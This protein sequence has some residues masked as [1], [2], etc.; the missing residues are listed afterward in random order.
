METL[1]LLSIARTYRRY[2]L[3]GALLG[4]VAIAAAWRVAPKRYQATAYVYLD[5]ASNALTQPG[6]LQGATFSQVEIA[7]SEKVALQTLATLDPSARA[8]MGL[9]GDDAVTLVRRRIEVK[10]G[11]DSSVMQLVAGQPVPEDA[12]ALANAAAAAYLRVSAAL[13]AAPARQRASYYDTKVSDLQAAALAAQTEVAAFQRRTG[14]VNAAT[15][16][17][18][19]EQAMLGELIRRTTELRAQYLGNAAGRNGVLANPEGSSE[20]LASPVVQ[21]LRVDVARARTR[22]Q[23]LGTRLGAN[24]PEYIRAAQELQVQ[25]HNLDR[26]I[27]LAAASV[28]DA[29]RADTRSAD[30]LDEVVGRQK[31][32]I[33]DLS[34][35]REQLAALRERADY[36]RKSL[37]AMRDKLSDA[38]VES[39]STIAPASLLAAAQ[40]PRVP[41]G[42]PLERAAPLAAFAGFLLAG[43][44]ALVAENRAPRLRSLADLVRRRLPIAVTIPTARAA[45]VRDLQPLPALA[46]PAADRRLGR[47]LVAAGRLSDADNTRIVEAQRRDGMPYG[48]AGM[49]LGL[50]S[51]GDV[52]AALSTQYGMR[53]V[54]SPALGEHTPAQF[55]V[56]QHPSHPV[57]EAVRVLRSFLMVGAGQGA[58]HH[59]IAIASAGAGDGRSFVAAN[60]AIA[61]AQAGRKTLLVEADMRDPQLAARFGSPRREG[62]SNYLAGLIQA[63]PLLP[64]DTARL[65][66]LLPAGPRPPNPQELLCSPRFGQLLDRISGDYE[67]VLLDTPALAQGADALLIA[68]QATAVLVVAD[69]ERTELKR[70]DQ[71]LDRF[72]RS[73]A[74]IAG[75]VVNHHGRL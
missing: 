72:R 33:V 60:L 52:D 41:T 58:R 46:D 35:N 6:G 24:H 36:A 74:D 27:A 19:A 12:A 23:E 3:A 15:P 31:A 70:L 64:L 75:V 38:L 40:V 55:V 45:G 2:L 21:S 66:E 56:D 63:P 44:G 32:V 25:E 28:T 9:G 26:E 14:L 13:K 43:L 5:S 7:S 42:L 29:G 49:Q 53:R 22:L 20:V 69:W 10:V 37:E 34:A 17:G 47:L 39:R 11:R 48:T 65:L 51:A 59:V 50:L 73:G 62:L 8:R 67:L 68:A 4:A 54:T 18:D 16:A 1:R 71:L 57:A 30:K 61:F